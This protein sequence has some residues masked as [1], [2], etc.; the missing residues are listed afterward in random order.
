MT[1]VLSAHATTV[2]NNLSICLWLPKIRHRNWYDCCPAFSGHFLSR[3][4]YFREGSAGKIPSK[5]GI[6]GVHFLKSNTISSPSAYYSLQIPHT[7]QTA[8]LNKKNLPTLAQAAR[9]DASASSSCN[10][11]NSGDTIRICFFDWVLAPVFSCE[12]CGSVSSLA[13]AQCEYHWA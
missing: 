3:Y 13:Q 4:L 11:A 2:M 5:T 10:R 1:D 8:S 7:D 12:G 6:A 9:Q